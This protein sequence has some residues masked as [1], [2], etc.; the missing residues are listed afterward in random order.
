VLGTDVLLGT[1]LYQPIGERQYFFVV[2]R[3]QYAIAPLYLF[4]DDV[5]VAQYEEATAVA[6]VDFG[7]NLIQY[8]EA[9]VGAIYGYRSFTLDSGSPL[10]PSQGHTS[11]GALGMAL[12]TCD[13]QFHAQR[14]ACSA[15]GIVAPGR[16]HQSPTG[17]RLPAV[18]TPGGATRSRPCDQRPKSARDT[19]YDQFNLGVSSTCPGCGSSSEPGL[20]VRA[21]GVPHRRRHSAVREHLHRASI[22]RDPQAAD[23]VWRGERV[24]GCGPAGGSVPRHRFAAGAAARQFR[25]RQRD[26]RAIYLFLGRP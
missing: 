17:R 4:E 1:E 26:N 11:V 10:F 19:V 21:A 23:S 2:P 14:I 25:L 3:L 24:D 8:G 22:E 5:Q 16:R 15:R 9:R 13:N 20:C 7:A 18:P 12:S 6:R